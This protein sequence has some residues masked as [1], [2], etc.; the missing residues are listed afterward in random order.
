VRVSYDPGN[1]AFARDISAGEGL[2]WEMIV[3]GAMAILVGPG[4]FILGFRRLHARL[5]LTSARDASGWVGHSGP[6]S[7]RGVAAGVVALVAVT[8]LLRGVAQG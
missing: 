2:A 5:N 4:S 6:H 7:V 8:I 3:F 1:P